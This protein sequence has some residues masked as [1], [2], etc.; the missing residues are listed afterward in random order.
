MSWSSCRKSMKLGVVTAR[1]FSTQQKTETCFHKH[2]PG[3]FLKGFF[4]EGIKV[5]MHAC[6]DIDVC[7]SVV[8]RA[9]L[10]NFYIEY[11]YNTLRDIQNN[12]QHTNVCVV[13]S[14]V[15]IFKYS[16]FAT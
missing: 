9:L 12:S 1:K 15:D 6:K 7:A 13:T 10:F 2:Y 4:S 5:K 8:K 11:S 14:W 16:N 3:L